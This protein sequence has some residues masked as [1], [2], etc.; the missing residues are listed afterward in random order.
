MNVSLKD[1]TVES[2]KNNWSKKEKLDWLMD[3][4]GDQ[5][6]R[7]AYTYVRSEQAAEDIAQDV[8]LKCYEK[9]DSFRGDSS[10]KTWLYKI[11]VNKCKDYLKSW[12]YKNIIFSELIVFFQKSTVP[13]ADTEFFL[14]KEKEE[15]SKKVLSLPVKYR[16]IIILFYYEHM[17][18]VEI[19]TLLALNHNTVKTRFTRAK[20][21][22]GKKLK[23]SDC[24][25]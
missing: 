10:Y 2:I 6:I 15:I 8:F 17:S 11:A 16:E 18:I 3:H 22:L 25:E 20:K 12:S 9:M 24:N 23:R 21:M 1:Q 19:S 4:Y 14:N 5:I 13:S 7:F